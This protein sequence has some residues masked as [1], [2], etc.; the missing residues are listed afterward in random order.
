MKLNTHT[1]KKQTLNQP[2]REVWKAFWSRALV[3]Q[4]MIEIEKEHNSTHIH[5]QTTATKYWQQYNRELE[6]NSNKN[7]QLHNNNVKLMLPLLHATAMW[8]KYRLMRDRIHIA[9]LHAM[10]ERTKGSKR[11]TK[12]TQFEL[13]S[14]LTQT[15]C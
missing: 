6:T 12:Q 7:L 15:K 3:I 2:G 4:T 14:I 5:P 13:N 8:L 9:T 10:K 1:H 11:K